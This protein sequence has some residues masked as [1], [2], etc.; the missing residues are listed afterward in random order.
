VDCSRCRAENRPGRRFCA[1]C[2]SPLALTCPSCGF[3]N[4]PDE[5]FCGGCGQSLDPSRG[6]ASRHA[7][8]PPR[9]A[10]EAER[11]QLTVMFCDLVGPTALSKRLD[12][13]DL[14]DVVRAYQE[15][16]ASVVDRFDGYIAQ[17]L[18]D[19]LLIYFGYPPGP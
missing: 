17:Y 18:G 11:R 5:A 12:P 8:A 10:A 4:E 15:V 13:E 16:S 2:G 19:G 14:R 9:G 6:D 1:R 3:P 7:T